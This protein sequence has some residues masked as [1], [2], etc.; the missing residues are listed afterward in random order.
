MVLGDDELKN[1]GFPQAEFSF[2]N[3]CDNHELLSVPH[4][5]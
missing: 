3:R 5:Q 4:S 1:L 2:D